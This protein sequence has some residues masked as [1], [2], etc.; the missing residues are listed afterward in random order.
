MY[1]LLEAYNADFAALQQIESAAEL[2]EP[3]EREELQ[4]LFG[5]SGLEVA[6]RLPSGRATPDNVE[7]RQ[8]AWR[9]AAELDRSEVRR[10]VAGRAVERYGLILDELL[11]QA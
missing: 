1:H 7:R 5:Q 10:A 3:A 4:A 8:Q 9:E 6:R 2:F 11:G